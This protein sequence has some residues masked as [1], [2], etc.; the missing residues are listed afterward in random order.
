MADFPA[1]VPTWM[2]PIRWITPYLPAA[3]YAIA[4]EKA[5]ALYDLVGKTVAL[6]MVEDDRFVLEIDLTTG[7]V[8]ISSFVGELIWACAY[9][10]TCIYEEV[11]MGRVVTEELSVDLAADP[12]EQKNLL[13]GEISEGSPERARADALRAR[14]D[15][16]RAETSPHPSEFFDDEKIKARLKALG[17]LEADD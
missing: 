13:R 5:Q 4:P 12:L 7:E 15:A 8:S 1:P 9:A 17:Y 14:L 3:P 11:F 2:S 6:R 16:F 10:Y